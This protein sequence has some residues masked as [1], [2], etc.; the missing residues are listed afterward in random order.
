MPCGMSSLAGLNYAGL[1]LAWL[2]SYSLAG[3]QVV[4]R[5]VWWFGRWFLYVLCG[6]FG[7]NVM[8]NA[9]KILRGLLKNFFIIFYLLFTLGQPVCLPR[10]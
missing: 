5:R 7:R 8:L 4:A 10:L 1:C 6:V 3:G 9:L 2:E